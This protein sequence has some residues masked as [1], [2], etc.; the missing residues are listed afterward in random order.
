MYTNQGYGIDPFLLQSDSSNA[1]AIPL[2]ISTNARREIAFGAPGIEPTW[3]NYDQVQSGAAFPDAAK[4]RIYA[5]DGYVM[6]TV[7][8]WA[9]ATFFRLGMRLLHGVMT[10]F[11]GQLSIEAGY[12][13]WEGTTPETINQWANAGFLREWYKAEAW[14]GAVGGLVS[15]TAYVYPIRWRSRKG[16][17]I[18]DDRALFLYFETDINSRDLAVFPRLRTLMGA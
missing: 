3:T 12:S 5:V 15:R 9:L 14:Q 17:S 1:I 8:D 18:G 6:I 10:N 11:D 7:N 13:M 2:T 4:Q 16:I